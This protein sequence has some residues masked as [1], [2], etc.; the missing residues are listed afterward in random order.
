MTNYTTPFDHVEGF[1]TLHQSSSTKWKACSL[2]SSTSLSRARNRAMITRCLC[3]RSLGPKVGMTWYKQSRDDFAYVLYMCCTFSAETV[4]A[5]DML[6]NLRSCWGGCTRSGPAA[7]YRFYDFFA[8]ILA[9]KKG[10]IWY[11]RPGGTS[12]S[13]HKQPTQAGARVFTYLGHA[14]VPKNLLAFA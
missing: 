1:C 11:G 8:G 12:G 7:V 9:A 2:A 4:Q 14:V 10:Q 3:T 6:T 13:L 5:A